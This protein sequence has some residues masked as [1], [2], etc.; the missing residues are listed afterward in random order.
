MNKK[1]SDRD[2]SPIRIRGARQNNLRNLDL[3]IEPGT[4][5][6]ITGPSGSGKSSLAYDT[7]Y[8]EG[9]RR[10]IETFSAYARQF[11]ERCDRPKVDK[12]DGVPPSIAINQSNGVKTSRSTVGTMTE[13][14]DC[15][16]LIFARGARL[17]C[18]T[19]GTPVKE[20]AAGDIAR[21]ML[22]WA[23]PLGSA[24]LSICFAV[25][26]PEGLAREV[27]L[28]GLSA[29]G[30]THVVKEEKLPAGGLVLQIAADRVRA[31]RLTI[32]RATEA[33]ERV[34]ELGKD[35]IVTAFAEPAEGATLV[36]RWVTDLTCPNCLRHY[37]APTPSRFSFNSPLGACPTCRGFG[38]VIGIDYSLVI[39]DETLSLRA[40]AVRPWRTASGQEC[41]RDL[42]RMAPAHDIPLDTPWKDLT[43]AQKSW[44][45]RGDK[46]YNGKNWR[47][48]WYGIKGYFDML[49][50]KS[51]KM[52]VRVQLAA[53]RGYSVCP[54][55]L[56]SRLTAESQLWRLGSKE[57]ARA[58]LEPKKGLYKRF[59]PRGLGQ[60]A[61]ENFDELPGLSLADITSLSVSDV[62]RFFE[63][64]LTEPIDEPSHLAADEILTRLSYLDDVGVGYLT[65]GRQSRTLSGG[66]VQRVNL[67]T[68]LGTN[69]TDT[70]FVLDEPSVGLHPRDMDR[71]NSILTGL[72][73]AGNTLVVVEHDPQVMTAADRIVDMGPGA[74]ENGGRIVGDG[75]PDE[76]RRSDSLTGL[77]LRGRLSARPAEPKTPPEQFAG[78]LT[79]E[80][81]CI[82][83]LKNVTV[84]IPLGA[85][86]ALTGVSGSG[87]ST[88]ADE[89]VA[90]AVEYLKRGGTGPVPAG[91]SSVKCHGRLEDAVYVGQS[92]IG[93]TSR[94]NPASYCGFFTDIRTLFARTPQAVS[95]GYTPGTFSFNAG[96]GRCP[97]CQGTGFERVE[98]QFLSDVLLTCPDCGGTRYRSETLEVR[99]NYRG[100]GEKNIAD[101][102]DM[103]ARE[104]LA[105]FEGE[106]FIDR[107]LQTLVDVGLD[108]VRLGQP[109]P[110]LSGGEA[111]RLKLAQILAESETSRAPGAKLY[112]FDEPTTGLH[113]D[114]V[115]KLL[116]VFRRLV[117]NGQTVLVIEHNLDV[118][119]A[120]DWVI[121]LGPEGGDEGGRIVAAATPEALRS[122]PESYTGRALAAYDKMIGEN[123]VPMTGLF[124][125]PHARK[126]ADA[127]RP[128]Q[129]VWRGAR[130]GDLGIFGAREHNLKNIDVVIP[131]RRMTAVTGVSGS[132]KSTL[133]FG[134]VFSEGQ[135]RYL[136]SLNAYA[137]SIT[138]PPP[139]ADV[140]SIVGIAPTV[141]IEQRTSRGGRKSTVATVTEIQHYLRLL[142]V[143]LGEQYCPKCGILVTEQTEEQILAHVM[144]SCRGKRITLLAPVVV[145]RK[146][147]YQ[148]TAAWAREKL[149]APLIRVD[150]RWTSTSPFPALSRYKEH[151]IEVPTGSFVVTPENEREIASALSAALFHGHGLVCVGRGTASLSAPDKPGESE[152]GADGTTV[153]STKRAC[154]KCAMSFPEPDP[155]LFSYN[156]KMGWCPTCQ[157]TGRA[158]LTGEDRALAD[159]R[160]ALEAAVCPT[161][162]GARLNPVALAVRF[163]GRSIGETTALTVDEALEAM[164]TLHL[165]GREEAVGGDAVREIVS[166]LEF[167]HKV[168]LGYLTLDRD[169]PSL[170]GGEAQRIRLAAQIG[171]TLQGVCY[172]LDE[173]TIGLHARDNAR[174]VDMLG[175][176]KDKGNTVI[177]VEHD[178]ELIRRADHIVDIGPGA[179]SRGGE[180][181]AEGTLKDICAEPRS[182]TGKLLLHPLAHTGKARRPVTDET[183][184]LTVSGASLHN[185]KDI[186]VNIPLGRLVVV[187]GVSGSGKSTLVRD[188]LR[189]SLEARLAS[190]SA[191]VTGCRNVEWPEDA[192]GR[193][194]EVDQTPIGKTPRSCPAT[195]VEFF[196]AIR[197]LFAQ[198]NEAQARG[199][200][201]TRFSFNTPE[202]RC[203]VCEGQGQVNVEMNFLPDVRMPCEACRGQRFDDETLA[204]RWMDKSI[205]DVLDLSVDD[206][207][208]VFANRPRI[209]RPLRL[210]QDVGLGYLRLGQPSN[211][212]SGGEAQRI[213]LVS[214]LAKA[215]AQSRTRRTAHTF[216][217]LDEPT[218]GLH[219]ADVE[220]LI[221]VLHA[222]VE[223]GNTVVVIEHNLDIIADADWV[224][225]LGPEGGPE[226][227]CVTGEG[228]PAAVADLSTPTG[229]ALK[230]FLAEHRPDENAS[231]A[232]G[233]TEEKAGPK[234]AAKP[235]KPAKPKTAP[236]KAAAKSRRKE[237]SA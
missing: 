212:L 36:R 106:S 229:A 12:I 213:K 56:G 181:I 79:V 139:K 18:G 151:T 61:R 140:E 1:A 50:S 60:A 173:P 98:M 224:I 71:I 149:G 19:C 80:G 194:L 45:I 73:A 3:D 193:V 204:V 41:L 206:A 145:S 59:R 185:L 42:I 62:R 226:G 236:V 214:E 169:A 69:L 221:G 228:E 174:L 216:Y 187:T 125:Q 77:Y 211:T 215:Y 128:L 13:I 94:G 191:S 159:D 202:G 29:Q 28:G 103:T 220:K 158:G 111:Q 113:F 119:G 189:T 22:E 156:N 160:E 154:P 237:K 53:Y 150:G 86:T 143:K 152:P 17:F 157:G 234:A 65:L 97:T 170:S 68:A 208:E 179:G 6:V 225:D 209:A 38:R 99:L 161:C 102:L 30:F 172:V 9:Q 138:Q 192:F 147:I 26:V 177:V 44:V 105:Y 57:S 132:G 200:Q 14:T 15:L 83:N 167:L 20:H 87:K 165:A 219:M 78:A 34:L 190:P 89:V 107:S 108:Y 43:D 235:K 196:N 217:I 199:Y 58:A 63:A 144:K 31:A 96:D 91:F 27:V 155:R 142:Y 148:D 176:L 198:T 171:S 92:E 124:A 233:K 133:A 2:V 118:I 24:R 129:S 182:I 178:E 205:G 126:A 66:E 137:R 40:G 112:I 32:P 227:G 52:H 136:E 11:L 116:A 82:H 75:T 222:L 35:R 81:A 84:R 74:G 141:A 162:H 130:R 7:L 101:V 207:L 123:G 183:P 135:R 88:L 131:K 109:L 164:R 90:P 54:D 121:D 127:G 114:D 16:K 100:R 195:Y 4:M 67:T 47:T 51:Y 163:H 72:K 168:G 10:Y 37:T 48:H 210:M 76:V 110:T 223:A 70:L 95:R 188:V 134:I 186:T 39:P 115:R 49:E 153:F 21:E 117:R 166:R 203:P 180:R 33:V 122:V 120:A 55:C 230:A 93:K 64:F 218:V 231:E 104:A 232:D 184:R 8:A 146:G 197:D 201:P 175:E 5:T 46:G 25:T 23:L 85:F